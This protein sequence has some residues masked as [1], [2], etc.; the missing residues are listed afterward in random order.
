[1]KKLGVL[2]LVI[3]SFVLVTGCSNDKK[4]EEEKEVEYLEKEETENEEVKKVTIIDEESNSRPYAVVINNFPSAVKV[5]SGLND[6]YLVYEM[7]VE[8]GMTR[9]LALFKDKYPARV[10]TVRSAR[11]NFLDYVMENDAIFVHFG[12]SI[13]AEQ[14]IPQ[15]GIN[16]IDGNS[17]DPIPFWRENPESLAWEHTAY[18]SLEKAKEYATNVKGYRQTT[19]V[20]SP[21]K[22]TTSEVKLN[23]AGASNVYIKYSSAYVLEFKYNSNTKRYTRYVN[24]VEHKDYFTKESYTTKNILLLELGVGYAPNNYYL[25]F[26][27]VGT[28]YGFYIVNG[29]YKKIIWTKKDRASQTTYTYEDGTEVQIEDGN[30]YIVLKATNNA[31]SIN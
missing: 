1:M 4:V 24:G 19:E 13:Y 26:K 14:Q 6:A 31:Y 11:H 9:S 7:P 5:Q 21:L 27:N 15:L 8:G 17:A 22:Y 23:G 12:W 30:T 18:G 2:F 16:N 28:G 25:D 29:E 3:L 10:G 20:K